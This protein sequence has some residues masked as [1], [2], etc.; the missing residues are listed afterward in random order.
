MRGLLLHC[1]DHLAERWVDQRNLADA[2]RGNGL[3]AVGDRTHE[4]GVAF[5]FPDVEFLERHVGFGQRALQAHAERAARPPEEIDVVL[6]CH[7][8]VILIDIHG[9]TLRHA[10]GE[11]LSDVSLTVSSGDRLGVVGQNGAGKSTL[12]GIATGA[13]TPDSGGV[14]KEG[15]VQIASLLQ[16]PTFDDV[17]ALEAVG[18][19]WE[20][21]ALLDRLGLGD[22]TGDR[23]KNMSGGEQRRVALARALAA[24]SDLLILDEPT[25]H[26]D[27]DAIDWLEERLASFKGGL[28]CVSH[29]RHM[30]DAVTTRVLE[31]DGGKLYIHD[32][33]YRAF[34]DGRDAR[35]DASDKAEAVRKNLARREK[36]WLLRGAPARTSKAKARIR[37]AE[38][39]QESTIKKGIRDDAL[40]LHSTTPRLGNQVIE[41]SDVKVAIG[42]RVLVEGFTIELDPRER[43]GIVGPNG[44]GKSTLLDTIAQRREPT[45]GTVRHGSTVKLAYFDQ[46]GRELDPSK[47]V[48]DMFTGGDRDA[49]WRD[50]ALLERF[51]F[52]AETQYSPVEQLSG[53]ERRRLQLVL[54]LAEEPNVLLLDEPTNDLDLDTLRAL[55]DFLEDFPGA[56]VAVSHDRA[57]LE[58]V[59]DD[60]IVVDESTSVGRVPGGFEAWLE[61]RRSNRKRGHARSKSSTDKIGAPNKTT[62][63]YRGQTIRRVKVHPAAPSEGHREGHAKGRKGGGAPDR[64]VGRRHRSPGNGQSWHRIDHRTR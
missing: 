19:S 25:N 33:G 35:I 32:G 8:A 63:A 52:D 15:G 21:A 54:V 2:H 20:A 29:D 14:R 47:R 53:G 42:D 27:I 60:V 1:S 18:D 51:W 22:R 64:T 10:R 41:L 58:R 62:C 38:A 49:D 39:I 55:E 40:A 46:L 59:V 31:V 16:R 23:V 30:L 44:T 3:V 28:L 34:L 45:K 24:P 37:T 11:I 56:V 50:K 5:V 57:F 36:E 13:I 48:I 6:V 7:G 61:E 4:R 9:V 12:L 26:L 43:L 17:T